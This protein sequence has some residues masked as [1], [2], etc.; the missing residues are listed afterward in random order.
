MDS[1]RIVPLLSQIE[2]WEPL[3]SLLAGS[4]FKSLSV[5]FN[6]PSSI[7]YLMMISNNCNLLTYSLL[8]QKPIS[9]YLINSTKLLYYLLKLLKKL[10]SAFESILFGK[11]VSNGKF[12]N[13]CSSSLIK[14]LSVC[15]SVN[16][17]LTI[18]AISKNYNDTASK[19]PEKINEK[20]EYLNIFQTLSSMIQSFITTDELKFTILGF[21]AVFVPKWKNFRFLLEKE[22]KKNGELIGENLVLQAYNTFKRL[23][24][25]QVN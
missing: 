1:K 7:H 2:L 14:L 9:D 23:N 5:N 16:E 13:E 25:L 8:Y 22:D 6:Q 17:D 18:F 12:L 15:I 21:L 4:Y 11:C 20:T 24:K 3:V 10:I 19:N